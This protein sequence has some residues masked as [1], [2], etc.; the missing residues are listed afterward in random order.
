[1]GR[2]RR[3]G[4]AA[5]VALTA[6]LSLRAAVPQSLQS[7]DVQLQLAAQLM[8]DGRYDEAL[9]AYQ[10][11]AGAADPEAQRVARTGLV[12]AALR[13]A[14]FTLARA[15]A[16]LLA[17]DAPLDPDVVA[18][19]G[20]ALWAAGL[21]EEAEARYDRALEF[22]PTS[23]RARHGLA[24]SLAAQNRLQDAMAEATSALERSPRSSDL[25]YTLGTIQERLRRFDDAAASFTNFVN[26]LPN[27]DR[28]DRAD[29]ARSEIRF[30]RS[31]GQRTP[32]QGEPAAENAVHEI[33]FRLVNG[34]IIVRARV[35]GSPPQDFVVDTGA[36]S[37]ILSGSLARRVGVTPVTYTL[38][39]GVG[40]VGLRGLQLARIDSLELGSIRMRNVPCL[41]K[42]PPLRNLPVEEAEALSPL[43]L[44]Y[45][46]TIDYGARKLILARRLPDESADFELPLRMHRLAMVRGTI[47]GG[48]PA[49]FVVDTGG[50][51]ISI[52]QATAAL[53]GRP[54]PARKIALQ[55]F[56]SSGWD[57]DAFLMTGVDLSFDDIRYNNFSVVVL[58]LH[59]PSA[60]LG[61]QLGGIVG[62]RFLSG[63]RVTI[64]LDRS[65]LRL[66]RAT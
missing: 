4:M 3:L 45:S 11:A 21:F 66:R 43:A 17:E 65:V 39:A 51:E 52:S 26:L 44:G 2:R 28:S 56:G 9:E 53:L 42:D 50:E 16:G 32:L 40:S 8:E 10:S 48:H 62:H 15:T 22:D 31:F 5:A 37:T 24:R 7:V 6:S 36:E 38:S 49:S 14:Q 58:N 47:D 54:E 60:L 29:W 13:T 61:F 20:D 19:H 25:H 30:L 23:P 27:R 46:M 18:L 35:N 63:Y 1:M 12:H 64:D 59:T 41:I 34:K 55:V 57:T 33:D